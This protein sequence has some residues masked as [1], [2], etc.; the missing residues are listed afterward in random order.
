MATPSLIAL[1]PLKAESVRVPG[2]N[3]RSFAGKPLF[4]WMLETLLSLEE[5]D[6]VI[7]NTDARELLG[8][9]GLQASDRVVIRD[10][11]PTLCGH[12]VSMN[13]V[14]ADDV[15]AVDAEAYLMTHTT[16]PLLSANV[17]R[18]SIA[19]YRAAL[20]EGFDSLFSVNRVQS[21][22][23]DAEGQ[24]VNHDPAKLIPTQDLPAW[25]EENSNLYL[26]SRASFAQTQ[27]RI[28]ARPVL[29]P[30]P[31][32]EAIDIDTE[33]EWHLAEMVALSR[34]I[35]MSTDRFSAHQREG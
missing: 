1:M 34:L 2:K 35:G 20:G 31:P 3:F 24:P 9:H 21:R 18:A 19:R 6:Q 5:V 11:A 14:L 30:T 27:A 7:I 15:A 4:Q 16:N 22:F 23:Y 25:F 12:D 13:A 32:L 10:R 29:W 26:F 17:I 28:G 8:K 33:T